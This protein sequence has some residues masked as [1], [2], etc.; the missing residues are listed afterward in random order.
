M[1]IWKKKPDEKKTSKHGIFDNKMMLILTNK[2]R[3]TKLSI[4]IRLYSNMMMLQILGDVKGQD[5]KTEL[6]LNS[7]MISIY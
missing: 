1:L 4:R 3:L 5:D 7:K 6:N 2:K